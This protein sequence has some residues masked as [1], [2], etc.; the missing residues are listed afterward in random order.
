LR[1]CA[2]LLQ[3]AEFSDVVWRP[4]IVVIGACGGEG[5]RIGE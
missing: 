2:E 1:D 4:I 5:K 3:R